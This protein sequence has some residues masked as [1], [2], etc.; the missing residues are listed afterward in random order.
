[1]SLKSRAWAGFGSAALAG[2]IVAPVA[3]AAATHP[4]PTSKHHPVGTSTLNI[5]SF[6]GLDASGPVLQAWAQQLAAKYHL[7]APPG[8]NASQAQIEAYGQ[9]IIS[10]LHLPPAP[11]DD[12]S[13]AE[14]QAWLNKAAIAIGLPPLPGVNATDAEWEAWFTKAFGITPQQLMNKLGGFAQLG[15]EECAGGKTGVEVDAIN[16]SNMPATIAELVDGKIVGSIHL[17]ASSLKADQ[18]ESYEGIL[19]VPAGKHKVS[20]VYT[21]SGKVLDIMMTS[22]TCAAKPSHHHGS[23]PTKPGLPMPTHHTGTPSTGTTSHPATPVGPVV[24]TDY[25]KTSDND[26][27][28]YALAGVALALTGAG[29]FAARA[30]RR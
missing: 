16:F 12:A 23:N 19:P 14:V 13:D 7:P 26:E 21:A 30:R 20:L 17:K 4:A 24:Q 11:G 29:A 18:P 25:V 8:P 28:L 2:M 22:G 10:A 1:M 3:G 6:P 15:D 9:Q 5:P 27:A